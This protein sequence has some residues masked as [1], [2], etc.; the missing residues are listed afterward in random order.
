MT[1]IDRR[2]SG[3]GKSDPNRKKFIDRYKKQIKQAVNNAINKK[4]IKDANGSVTV[5]ID[6]NTTKEPTFSHDGETGRHTGVNSGNTKHKK[7][8]YLP[9]PDGQAGG[10][11]GV[12]G[13][14]EDNFTFQLTKDEF[15]DLYFG[16][17]EL[18]DFI[19]DSLFGSNQFKYKRAGYTRTGSPNKLN[20]VKTMEQAIGRRLAAKNQGKENPAYLDEIDLRYDHIVKK[21]YPIKKAIMFLI[22]DVSGSMGEKDKTIAKKFFILLYLFL[23]KCYDDVEVRFIRYTHEAQEVDEETFFYDP[24]SGGTI[25]ST[26]FEVIDNIIDTEVNPENTNIYI[27]QAAD[28]DNVGFDNKKL[29]GLL[30]ENILP[31]VQYM[32]YIQTRPPTPPSWRTSDP[33]LFTTYKRIHN[34]K[35]N[36]RIVETEKDVYPVLRELFERKRDGK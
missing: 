31:V 8:D 11:A 35:L 36:A 25:V 17:M 21:P 32:A 18:P 29:L 15:Y 1:I 30:N 33:D 10:G 13:G 22:M 34:E 12:S 9:K 19:K 26:G 4:G 28:G 7:G 23:T 20:V 16:D 6:K 2:T 27:A 5:T 24:H 14:G 3:K